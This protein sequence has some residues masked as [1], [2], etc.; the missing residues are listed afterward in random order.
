M[1]FEKNFIKGMQVLIHGRDHCLS[2]KDD[3]E[4]GY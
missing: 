2:E 1:H 3:D 4:D